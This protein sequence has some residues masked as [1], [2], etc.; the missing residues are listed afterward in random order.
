MQ[1][2]PDKDFDQLFK[3]K[4]KDAE[5]KPSLDLWTNIAPQTKPKR[6]SRF[7]LLWL[8][9]ASIALVLSAVLW[10]NRT[11]KMQLVAAAVKAKPTKQQL[12]VG[13]AIIEPQLEE[14][15]EIPAAVHQLSGA[16]TS[17]T[18]VF[19]KTQAK[20]VDKIGSDTM[21]PAVDNNHLVIK[22]PTLDQ[23]VLKQ[24][25]PTAVNEEVMYAQVE[26]TTVAMEELE[27]ADE[28]VSKKGIRNM[29]DLIN[30]V[31]EKVDKRDKKLIK[32]DT[33]DDDN[34]TIIGLN[35][36]FVKLNKRDK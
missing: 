12:E 1:H 11:E 31:V 8:A 6:K 35:I 23:P 7:P 30:Y 34:S 19:V 25:S 29:G 33:D 24:I 28:S 21:Q 32:F 16:K 18:K 22:K 9:A 14:A 36:G 3:D 17:T 4:F 26:T 10:S 13:E 5:V 20:V 27:F 2:I 15:P